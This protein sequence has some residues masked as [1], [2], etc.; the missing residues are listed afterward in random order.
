MRGY[1]RRQERELE[2]S[3]RGPPTRP[4]SRKPEAAKRLSCMDICA[5]SAPSGGGRLSVCSLRS[6]KVGW[7]PWK[8]LAGA[9][10]GSGAIQASPAVWKSKWQL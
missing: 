9:R 8:A 3:Y 5:R 10:A 6:A 2:T 4:K 7:Q 1:M